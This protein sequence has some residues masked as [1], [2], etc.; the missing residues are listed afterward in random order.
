M[1]IFLDSYNI[2]YDQCEHNIGNN[3]Y[4]NH[5]KYEAL[6]KKNSWLRR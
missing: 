3:I 5:Y 4:S 2:N 6:N 1:C